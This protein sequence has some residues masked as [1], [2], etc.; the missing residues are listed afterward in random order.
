MNFVMSPSESAHALQCDAGLSPQR[1]P[2]EVWVQAVDRL[3]QAATHVAA[4]ETLV[5]N[6]QEAN[7]FYEP[8]MLLPALAK[9][10][11]PDI[12]LHLIW[13]EPERPKEERQLIGVVPIE[14]AKRFRRM[15]VSV[16]RFWKH[17]LCSLTTPLLHRDY[18][19]EALTA[20]LANAQLQ[21][22]MIEMNEAH[23]EGPFQQ[24]LIDVLNDRLALSFT[25]DVWNR[26]A[27]RLNSTSEEYLAKSLSSGTRK[28]VKR[29]RKRLGE[30]GHVEARVLSEEEPI[31][32]W[33]ES[34]LELEAAGWKG[35]SHTAI[36]C[37]EA[38]S[39]FFRTV[40]KEA[41]ARGQFAMLGLFL[42][43]R[44]MALKCNFLSAGG[45]GFA[46]KIAYDERYAKH[47][48]GLLLE[49]DNIDWLHRHPEIGW[50]DSC[51]VP[52]HPM[53]ERLWLERRTVQ[54][55]AI[56]TGGWGANMALGVLYAARSLKRA[57][58]RA[59]HPR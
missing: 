56:S 6:A 9:F 24:T 17:V 41:H 16:W 49:L 20:F 14:R 51:A 43:G 55:L 40:A 11:T 21:A 26:A 37:D 58:S 1:K 38:Q 36:G 46:F 52:R 57:W 8:W 4:W 7:V 34:F 45:G 39:E 12:S 2:G 54:H 59:R 29:H 44:A 50:L 18:A 5:R 30:L 33:L 15:P 48:P 42:D 27:I 53:I 23:A 32:S 19:R 25:I 22:G 28:E 31:E 13:R 10:G 3:E 47:S 35:G